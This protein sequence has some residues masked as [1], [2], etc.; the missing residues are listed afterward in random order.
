MSARIEFFIDDII[1][2][3]ES[4]CAHLVEVGQGHSP[5]YE[6]MTGLLIDAMLVRD[7]IV[8]N[9]GAGAYRQSPHEMANGRNDLAG[10]GEH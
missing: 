9:A 6:L 7:A 8:E 5:A 3:I 10:G 2:R 1:F 4:G